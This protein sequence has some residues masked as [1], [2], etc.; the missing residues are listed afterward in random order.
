MSR[1]LNTGQ[2]DTS[3]TNNDVLLENA[4]N[5]AKTMVELFPDSIPIR[6]IPEQ[7]KPQ[8][9]IWALQN[10]REPGS[11]SR[12]PELTR[13]MLAQVSTLALATSIA[14]PRYVAGS[15]HMGTSTNAADDS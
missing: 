10:S 6:F 8:G 12:S 7:W 3:D 2:I 11:M 9:N 5:L 1:L 13:L 4:A 15:A 14:G